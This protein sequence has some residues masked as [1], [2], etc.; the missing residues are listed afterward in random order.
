MRES[1]QARAHVWLRAC[2]SARP[3]AI[4]RRVIR[5]ISSH[6]LYV[7]TSPLRLK[8]STRLYTDL[9]TEASSCAAVTIAADAT[10][11][12]DQLKGPDLARLAR[13]ST[14]RMPNTRRPLEPR[15][16]RAAPTA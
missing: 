13:R 14:T 2:A 6:S 11:P 16:R 10:M 8:K 1:V 9:L 12:P 7:V 3:C 4:W 15:P 5:L